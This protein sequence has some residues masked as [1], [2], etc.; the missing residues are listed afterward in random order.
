MA[1]LREAT[2]TDVPGIQRVRHSVLENRLV[3]ATIPDEAVIDAMEKTGRGW[4]VEVDGQVVGFAIGSAVTGN[5]W[6]LF[7]DPA[8]EA[9]G[10]GRRLHDEMIAWLWSR[11][12]ER[13]WLSTDPDTRAHRFYE[14][15]GWQNRGAL[16]N[17]EVLFER[18]PPT[19]ASP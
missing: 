4:I 19:K 3:S 14:A 7:V 2:R 8:H 18:Y 17:G 1:A 6:A 5:I 11:G 10:H 16:P 9:R 12:L 15:A 13:L